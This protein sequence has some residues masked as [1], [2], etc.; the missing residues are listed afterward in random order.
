MGTETH[1]TL[2]GVINQRT[3]HVKLNNPQMGTET[4]I[5]NKPRLPNKTLLVKLN[6]PQMGT[7][8]THHYNEYKP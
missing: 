4:I 8:T 6:N 1:Y 7:E 3:H 2:N 5:L